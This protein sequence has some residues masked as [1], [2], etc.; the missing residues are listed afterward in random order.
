MF[1][2][3]CIVMFCGTFSPLSTK[4]FSYEL[5][6]QKC[7]NVCVDVNKDNTLWLLNLQVSLAEA[8]R[9]CEQAMEHNAQL[10][11]ENSNLMSQVNT[12]QGSVQQLEEEVSET[13]RIFD[14]IR[15]VSEK[16]LAISN[17][18]INNVRM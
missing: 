12:L 2:L 11:N 5:S 1:V 9:K 4:H 18:F 15:R 14:K 16:I 6:P 17:S 10:E 8:E 13:Q 3:S 7:T